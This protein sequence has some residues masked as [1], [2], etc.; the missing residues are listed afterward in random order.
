ME[1]AVQE[2]IRTLFVARK[3]VQNP[4]RMRRR[5]QL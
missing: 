4:M 5:I 2:P 3:K 1:K